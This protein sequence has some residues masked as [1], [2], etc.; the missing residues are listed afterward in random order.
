M[1]V[2]FG[3]VDQLIPPPLP[4]VQSNVPGAARRLATFRSSGTLETRLSLVAFTVS[5]YV[6][7][8]AVFPAVIVNVE[9]PALAREGGEKAAV[10]FAGKPLMPRA[11]VPVKLLLV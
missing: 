1:F 4:A 3:P 5:A 2:Q 9:E 10:T 6:P 8:A 7:T 11:A